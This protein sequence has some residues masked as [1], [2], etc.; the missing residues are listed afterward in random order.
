ML[1][2]LLSADF[3]SQSTFSK[4]SF[5][6]TIRVANSLDPVQDQQ[7]VGPELSPNCLQRLP[8]DEKSR[9]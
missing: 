3:F 1:F 9:C 5:W 2:F 8:A 4:N 7:N 6:N